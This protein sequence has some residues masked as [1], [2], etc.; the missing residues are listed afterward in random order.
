MAFEIDD[1]QR[2][3]RKL[4]TDP[5]ELAQELYAMFASKKGA[6]PT[7]VPQAPTE[8]PVSEARK[9]VEFS[10]FPT[11]PFSGKNLAAQV[12]AGYQLPQFGGQGQPSY[13]PVGPASKLGDGARAASKDFATTAAPGTPQSRQDP[14]TPPTFGPDGPTYYFTGQN[15]PQKPSQFWNQQSGNVQPLGPPATVDLPFQFPSL[16]SFPGK[17]KEKKSGN[18]YHVIL[19]REGGAGKP[20]DKPTD[21]TCVNVDPSETIP[22]DT[23]LDKCTDFGNGWEAY[24][25]VWTE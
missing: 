24:P 15:G 21:V 10:D 1:P 17:V 8:S 14:F 13:D 19:Y 12:R 6:A 11:S 25:P 23:W 5:N 9:A 3:N 18:V 20:D 7:A 4:W 22:M 16:S 2:L